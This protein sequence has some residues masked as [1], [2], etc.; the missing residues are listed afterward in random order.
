MNL[1]FKCLSSLLLLSISSGT[2]SATLNGILKGD[3]L[4][5]LNA[6]DQGDYIALSNWQPLSGVRAT[7]EWVPGTFMS[8]PPKTITLRSGLE[9]VEIP[10]EVVGIEYGLGQG[11]DKFTQRGNVPTSMNRCSVSEQNNT[12][13]RVIGSRCVANESY[14]TEGELRYTPFQFV[15]PLLEVDEQALSDTFLESG[16]GSGQY[17]GTVMV[18]PAYGYKSQTGTWTYRQAPAVP[19]TL[20]ISYEAAR[21]ESI[22]V[23]GNSEIIPQYNT[24][25]QTVSGSTTFLVTAKGAFPQGINL[26]FE[27]K[28]YEMETDATD[29]TLPYSITCLAC[30]DQVVVNSGNLVVSEGETTVVDDYNLVQFEL[31]VHYDDITA[32]QIET[33]R[34]S[35]EFTV[36]FEEAL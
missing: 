34:Y 19:M 13:A 9:S 32:D 16:V 3:T 8:Q 4:H 15:R 21:L 20:R 10:F 6:V 28:A 12:F 26:T 22:Q 35:D 24:E 18:S 17:S 14:K 33:G 36:Y 7:S 31:K 23:T 25:M 5:W 30:D 27:S 11:A 29:K 2:H 1:H